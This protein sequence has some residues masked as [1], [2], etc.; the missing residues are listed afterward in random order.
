MESGLIFLRRSMEDVVW[1]VIGRLEVPVPQGRVLD[2]E[3]TCS[4]T[5]KS[6]YANT[7]VLKL[8]QVG[9]ASSLRRSGERWLR[10]SANWP[11]NFGIRGT[12]ARRSQ[13]SGSGNCLL[14]TQDSANS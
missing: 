14:K 7:T 10:N 8:T 12:F 9:E 6:P 2:D 11:R 13:Q 3:V 5:K 4:T 1:M